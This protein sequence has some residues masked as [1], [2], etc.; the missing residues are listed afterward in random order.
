MKKRKSLL[1][2]AGLTLFVALA[3]GCS[4][5]DTLKKEVRQSIQ[6][7]TEMKSYSF[8][9]SANVRADVP[10]PQTVSLT[11]QLS[12]ALANSQIK[13]QGVVDSQAARGEMK[14]NV[15]PEGNQQS[16]DLSMLFKDNKMYVSTPL[17]N[18]PDE[19]FEIDLAKGA[20]IGPLSAE[21]FQMNG[22][23]ARLFG[24]IAD[25]VEPGS[26]RQ[27]KASDASNP[28]VHTITAEVE[29]KNKEAFLTQLYPKLPELL[30]TM[31][32]YHVINSS[33]FQELKSRLDKL[34]NEQKK[35]LAEQT[36]L[37]GP[38]QLQLTV[39]GESR[40]VRQTMKLDL[41][42]KPETNDTPLGL[43]LDTDIAYDNLDQ[44]PSFKMEVPSKTVSIDRLLQY[45]KPVSP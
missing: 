7:Q 12:E 5:D 25:A 26:F 2:L 4:D 45:I 43:K 17:V 15:K 11:S 29:D 1:G 31:A 33:Q 3:A 6:K 10:K 37:N 9:G 30:D 13:W 44:A 19:Y 40:V 34:D 42:F 24:T 38:L 27:S 16:Y 21:T 8:T 20:Q 39:D 14:L 23:F 18:A 28:N 22:M 41:T 32:S 35:K 36:T